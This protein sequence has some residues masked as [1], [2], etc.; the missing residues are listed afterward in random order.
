MGFESIKD[1]KSA[2]THLN[3]FLKKATVPHALIFTGPNGVGRCTVAKFFAMALNCREKWSEENVKYPCGVC[4]SC[5][6]I[7]TDNHPDIIFIEP[8]GMSIKILQIRNMMEVLAMK[9]YEAQKRVVIISD[10]QAMNLESSNALLKILEEPP[11]RTHLILIC[12]E[13][14][15][16]IPTIISRCQH[17]RFGPISKK[18]I[19]KL[20]IEK[21]DIKTEKAS[22]IS[23]MANGSIGKALSINE[24]NWLSYRRWIFKELE[25]LSC[26]KP[27][28]LSLAFAEKLSKNKDIIYDTFDLIKTYLR[29]ILIFKFSKEKIIN[30]DLAD[31]IE[32]VSQIENLDAIISKIDAVTL[33]EKNIK[34][35][36]NLKL[37]LEIM[38]LRLAD[39]IV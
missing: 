23:I 20:L 11:E 28:S 22:V 36:A 37:S 38:I 15:E 24:G 30:S 27:L 4:Q 12:R 6:K 21:N 1:Q 3:S 32:T 10:A 18:N 35:N 26:D 13:I 34:A 9:P 2:I 7:Q 33:A 8:V 17:I 39:I 16:L 5:R 14:S 19:E 31:I 29:D 25:N